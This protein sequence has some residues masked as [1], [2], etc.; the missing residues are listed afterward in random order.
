LT[1]SRILTFD[2]EDWFHILE[3]DEVANIEKWAK[4]ESR[5]YKN[6]EYILDTLDK[7][8][9]KATFFILGWIA[10]FYPDLVRQIALRGHD[11]GSHSYAH[12]LVYK[13]S[14]SDF[15]YDL[16]LSIEKIEACTGVVVNKYRAPG[17]SIKN[18]CFWAFDCLAKNGIEIDG[19]LFCAPRSHGGI[20]GFDINEPV[21]IKTIYGDNILCMPMTYFDFLNKKIILEGGGYF[22]IAPWQFLNFVYSRN[23]R[24]SMSYFHPRDFDSLQPRLSNLS[25]IKRF[26]TYA[27]LRYSYQKFERLIGTYDFVS[28]DEFIEKDTRKRKTI[29]LD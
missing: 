13:Q 28:V 7:F 3:V 8:D 14:K 29:S 22:R 11:L 16:R 20:S 24:Y 1:C 26:K 4:L 15:E 10:D 23:T 19:S 18:D 21:Y 17:F 27:G 2:I 6:V 25:L 5:I 12:K 9:T